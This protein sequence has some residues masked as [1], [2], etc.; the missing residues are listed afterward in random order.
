MELG[1][2]LFPPETLVYSSVFV[3]AALRLTFRFCKRRLLPAP[4]NITVS[5]RPVYA[6]GALYDC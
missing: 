5:L 3:C 1:K 4:G 6:T 2:F